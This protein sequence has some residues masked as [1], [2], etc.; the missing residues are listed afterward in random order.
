MTYWLDLFTGRTWEEFLASGG[1][2]S[3]F[4]ESRWSVIQK[5]K[6]GDRLL[7]YVTGV[8]RWIGLLEVTGEP[9]QDT[10]PIWMDD[11]FPSRFPVKVLIALDPEHAVPVHSLAD[12]LSYFQKA[13]SPVGWTG[14]FRG[15]PVREKEADALV[16][17]E[18]LEKA[19][20]N[21]VSRPVDKAKWAR[22]PRTY[23]SAEGPVTIPE[24]D[25]TPPEV[26][27]T[28]LAPVGEEAISHE[29]I[30][31]LLLS[32]GSEMG[33]GLWVAKNDRNKSYKGKS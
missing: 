28:V 9:Y 13:T 24:E 33:F 6:P 31:S 15:S 16:V 19:S 2:V 11:T 1:N 17:V 29:E 20:Q 12:R 30:Q 10:T 7:C 5:V 4:R 32:L 26:G 23:E 27:V 25:T 21:P 22:R 18:A 14:H 8:S 3:G